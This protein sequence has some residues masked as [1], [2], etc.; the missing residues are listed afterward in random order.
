MKKSLYCTILF[1]LSS[2]LCF[3]AQ[4]VNENL[5]VNGDFEDGSTGWRGDENVVPETPD[6]A[7]MICRIMSNEEGIAE[8]HQ[9]I[10]TFRMEQ[11]KVKFRV[12]KSA[13]HSGSEWLVGIREGSSTS[14]RSTPLRN[15][16]WNSIEYTMPLNPKNSRTTLVFQVK[17]GQR[18]Y[19]C[20][21]DIEVVEYNEPSEEVPAETAKAGTDAEK[22]DDGYRV[23]TDKNGREIEARVVHVDSQAKR[24]T[25]HKKG[26]DKRIT[27]PVTAFTEETQ[28]YLRSFLQRSD[29]LNDKTL[30]V[31]IQK[32]KKK[33]ADKS[34]SGESGSRVSIYYEGW[35]ELL[36]H[37]KSIASFSDVTLEYALFY[38]QEFFS[39]TRG[40]QK[41]PGTLYDKK[42]LSFPSGGKTEERTKEVILHT[43]SSESEHWSAPTQSGELEGVIIRLTFETDSGE[44]VTREIVYPEHL[45]HSWTTKTRSTQHSIP[46]LE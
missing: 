10:K 25:V 4:S 12:R 39:N 5:I 18:G 20:F 28:S 8:F 2:S 21:D 38:G 24:V 3:P 40:M 13:D 23:L 46:P 22:A 44:T 9:T 6:A 41:N 36:I 15:D 30:T 42:T 33:I 17:P 31:E 35:M 32:R 27:V 29:F 37:N 7:N 14:G 34:T 19:I 11:I 1:C 16:D 26:S 43:S 45:E